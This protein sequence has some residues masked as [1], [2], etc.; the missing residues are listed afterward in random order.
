MCSR[1]AFCSENVELSI[2]LCS[3]IGFNR[4]RSCV[5]YS[6]TTLILIY[7]HYFI[8]TNS[9][10]SA[11]RCSHVVTFRRR[12]DCCDGLISVLRLRGNGSKRNGVV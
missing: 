7:C 3:I 6:E 2:A 1:N 11:E 4:Q 9:T 12:Q 5:C 10:H 8:G